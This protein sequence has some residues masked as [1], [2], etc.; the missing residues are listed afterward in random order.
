MNLQDDPGAV[1]REL[2]PEKPPAGAFDLDGIVRDGYKARR[3]HRAV[4]AGASATSVAVIAGVLA[5]S[6]TGLP[7]LVDDPDGPP[8]SGEDPDTALS[9]YPAPGDEGFGDPEVAQAL[10]EAGRDAFV[11]LLLDTGLFTASDFETVMSE[12]TEQEI[13]EYA[14]EHSVSP[15]EAEEALAYV[16]DNGDFAF[17]SHL[18]PGN[19]GQVQLRGYS[20]TVRVGLD[21]SG[22]GGRVL[23]DVEA[24]LPGGWTDEPGPTSEQYFPQHLIDDDAAEFDRTELDDGRVLYTADDGCEL[25]AAVVY[26]DGSGLRAAWNGC[27]GNPEADLER[28]VAAVEAMP[29]ADFDTTN[30]HGVGEVVDVPP[31]WL[32]SDD[33]W[34]PW[35]RDGAQSTAVAAGEVLDGL[36]PGAV[37]F[38]PWVLPEL[39]PADPV[40]ENAVAL[41]E[42]VMN[43]SLPLAGGSGQFDLVYTL[44]GGWV[45]G[46][47]DA[48]FAGPYLARCGR[49]FDCTEAGTENGGTA[50]IAEKR[51]EHEADPEAGVEEPW[52]EGEY[53]VTVVDP[54]GWAVMVRVSFS[55]P[56]I[57]LTVEE[58]TAIVAALPA[59]VYDEDAEPALGE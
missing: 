15:E 35:A 30:L 37:V 5:V 59:P 39:D 11:P 54:D 14:A 56:D 45:P 9:G 25:H 43:G 50:Y 28:F 2:M 27:D 40:D 1:L 51:I 17:L 16:A 8:A 20:A 53:E 3:R 36:V 29:Q 52:F 34:R 41:R 4:L 48:D 46:F 49:N 24:L 58:L 32:A 22:A 12:P 10:T 55:E 18:R 6:I 31:G 44:P 57:G 7:G 21:E 47:S 38:D 33:S 23:L 13:Q 42:Y 26:P 19:Y